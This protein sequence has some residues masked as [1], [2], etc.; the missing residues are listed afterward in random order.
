M[1]RLLR[2]VQDQAAA[3]FNLLLSPNGRKK[4][5]NASKL[6]VKVYD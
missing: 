5:P 3:I 6:R 4:K 1:R 2:T